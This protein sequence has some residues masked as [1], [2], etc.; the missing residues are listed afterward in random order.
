MLGGD[1]PPALNF[2]VVVVNLDQNARAAVSFRPS[3][4]CINNANGAD[5]NRNSTANRTHDRF[6]AFLDD[7]E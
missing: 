6:Y 2:L 3:L 1:A 7:G 4:L 5:A